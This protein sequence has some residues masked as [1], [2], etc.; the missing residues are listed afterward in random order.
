MRAGPTGF[1]TVVVKIP[2][3]GQ[4]HNLLAVS[5]GDRTAQSR[6]AKLMQLASSIIP[7]EP[8]P[9]IVSVISRIKRVRNFALVL[10][11]SWDC[12]ELGGFCDWISLHLDRRRALFGLPQI[13]GQLVP[14]PRLRR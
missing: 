5:Q 2:A 3:P 12:P 1:W 6:L 9:S 13:V 7:T 10:F 11:W 4:T 14:Q 8:M